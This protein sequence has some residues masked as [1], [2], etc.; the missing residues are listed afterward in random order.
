MYLLMQFLF[1][2]SHG[3]VLISY[4]FLKRPATSPQTPWNFS[5]YYV[6]YLKR[7]AICTN[8][9]NSHVKWINCTNITIRLL[10]NDHRNAG[11]KMEFLLQQIC[12]Y[13]GLELYVVIDIIKI[14]VLAIEGD[15]DVVM[16][17]VFTQSKFVVLFLWIISIEFYPNV[18]PKSSTTF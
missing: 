5:G 14:V 4:S 12:T 6:I 8:L 2:H 13:Y 18:R 9:I 7:T 3:V 10:Q 1:F 16:Y 11:S 17:L 15:Q